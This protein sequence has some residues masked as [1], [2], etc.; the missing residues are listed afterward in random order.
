[1][2]TLK[3]KCRE[4]WLFLPQPRDSFGLCG[5][6]PRVTP[7]TLNTLGLVILSKILH[8]VD[9]ISYCNNG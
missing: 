2:G 9:A 1:M 4:Y 5:E 3:V 7:N 8:E 6:D